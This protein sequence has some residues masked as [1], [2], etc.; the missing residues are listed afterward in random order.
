MSLCWTFCSK[1]LRGA[2]FCGAAKIDQVVLAAVGILRQGTAAQF[3]DGPA[4][5]VLRDE[6]GL[7]R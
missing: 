6:S 1:G 7:G 4:T 3:E 2:L 5:Q